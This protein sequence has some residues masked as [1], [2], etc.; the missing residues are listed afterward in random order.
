MKRCLLLLAVCTGLSMALVAQK[1]KQEKSVTPPAAVKTAYAQ[2]FQSSSNEKWEMEGKN[3][4][5]NFTQNGQ[6][7][8]AEFTPG[9]KLHETEVTITPADLPAAVTDY[10][11]RH[12]KGSPVKAATK[13]TTPDG[14][15]NYEAN[16]K[17]KVLVFDKN[18]KF[19][20]T[21]KD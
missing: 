20:K 5:V 7:M 18:G 13:I 2:S 9:G 14:G 6:Q 10:V 12:Y 21:E 8:S 1:E 17:G 16:V 19:S 15:I 3:Y 4:E 11:R